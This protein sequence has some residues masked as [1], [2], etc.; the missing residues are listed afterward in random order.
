M[1]R[2]LAFP[3]LRRLAPHRAL[4]EPGIA[5]IIYASA[6]L[7]FSDAELSRGARIAIKRRQPIF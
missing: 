4:L 7:R 3:S 6:N 1:D 5:M 2:H